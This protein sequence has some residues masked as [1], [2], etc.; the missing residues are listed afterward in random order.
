MADALEVLTARERAVFVARHYVGMSYREIATA[1]HTTEGNTGVIL[2]R[3][4]L[5]LRTEL[6]GLRSDE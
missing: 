6:S 2:H 5:K 4:H 1:L 3:A